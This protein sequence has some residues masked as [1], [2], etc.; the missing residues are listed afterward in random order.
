M[1]VRTDIWGNIARLLA[2]LLFICVVAN[3]VHEEA[4][5]HQITFLLLG[6]LI[7]IGIAYSIVNPRSSPVILKQ[8]DEMRF[9]KKQ[10]TIGI[11]FSV[12]LTLLFILTGFLESILVW[13]FLPIIITSVV[14]LIRHYVKSR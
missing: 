10:Y 4:V 14:L 11:V 5:P 12:I 3:T 1:R 9:R 13:L 6:S 7:A 8:Q 2:L